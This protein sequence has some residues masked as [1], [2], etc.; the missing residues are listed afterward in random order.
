[1]VSGRRGCSPRARAASGNRLELSNR[2]REAVRRSDSPEPNNQLLP[3][4]S[5]LSEALDFD[6]RLVPKTCV[7]ISNLRPVISNLKSAHLFV[8]AFPGLGQKTERGI[9]LSFIRSIVEE[10]PGG[11]LSPIDCG[12][13]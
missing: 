9:L 11:T 8:S 12:W 6:F 13:R 4:S 1:M 10:K 5:R 2:G 7:L 3:S